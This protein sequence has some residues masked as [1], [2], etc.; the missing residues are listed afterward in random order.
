MLQILL[1]FWY[2]VLRVVNLTFLKLNAILACFSGSP[3]FMPSKK[4]EKDKERTTVSANWDNLLENKSISI[5]EIDRG[6]SISMLLPF[7]LEVSSQGPCSGT[8][9]D[10]LINL[11]YFSRL[12]PHISESDNLK[13]VSSELV[14]SI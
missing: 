5:L 8:S 4:L 2:M 14:Y 9:K 1:L 10:I 6:S 3:I 11:T 7:L 13:A 12:G